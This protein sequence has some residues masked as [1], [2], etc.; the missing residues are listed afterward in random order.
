MAKCGKEMEI[1]SRVVGYYRP[2]KGWNKGKAEEFKDRK[3]YV[4]SSESN[5][6]KREN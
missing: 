2:L 4:V 5:V 6:K 3:E 1:F